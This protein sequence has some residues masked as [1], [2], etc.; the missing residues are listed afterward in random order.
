V[1]D[2][3]IK[4]IPIDKKTE[5]AIEPPKPS[6][7]VLPEWYKNLSPYFVNNGVFLQPGINNRNNSNYSAKK[8]IPLLDSFSSGYMITLPCDIVFVNPEEYGYRVI[9]DVSYEVVSEH[10]VMQLGGESSLPKNY[11]QVLKWN[12]FWRIKT[13]LGYSCLFTHPRGFFDLPFKT[14]DGIVDT[15]THV[16]PVNFPFFL[17]KNFFGK[18]EKGTPIC[19]VLPFKR[20]NWS[21]SIEKYEEKE[22]Y[23]SDVLRSTVE[24]SYKLNFWKRKKYR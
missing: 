18:V 6:S 19:Q 23:L 2:K 17:E 12:S 8:C 13:P 11:E 1:T 24:G 16:T 3:K 4:F 21:A 5:V 14:I 9:W 10:S 7:Q 22:S 20:E 15:D